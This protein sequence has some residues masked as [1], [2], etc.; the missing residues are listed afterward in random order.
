MIKTSKYHFLLSLALILTGIILSCSKEEEFITTPEA[1]LSFTTDTVLFDTVF[2]TLGSVTKKFKVHNPNDKSIRTSVRLGGGMASPYRINVDGEPISSVTE[3]TILPNDSIYIFVDVTIDPGNINQPFIQK[4]SIVFVTNGN[5]QDVKLI[6]WGQDAHYLKNTWLPDEDIVW[7]NDKPYV[8][9]DSIAIMPNR[10][11]TIE[12]GVKIYSNNNSYIWVAGT[13]I[14]NGTVDNPVIFTGIRTDEYYENIPGQWGGIRFLTPS[15]DNTITNCTVK[16][17]TIGIQVDSL[18]QNSNPKLTLENVRIENMAALGLF[19]FTGEI[20]AYNL[21]INNCCRVLLV[22]QSG[23]KYEFY[24]STFAHVNNNCTSHEPG[25]FLNNADWKNGSI[26]LVN[27][28][29]FKLVNS[30]VWGSQ[31]D[32]FVVDNTQGKGKVTLD[33]SYS[34]LRTTINDLN[35]NNN[36]LNKDPLFVLPSKYNFGLDTLSPA[37][38]KG[39][40]DYMS[41]P[42]LQKDLAGTTRSYAEPDMGALERKQ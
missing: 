18:S 42:P 41:L 6:A 2:T 9:F 27:D 10:K 17:G 39:T 32:E 26:T 14:V 21:L 15:K 4:D 3:F 37:I 33:L 36:I 7:T 23:G 40:I 13:M 25:I 1:K 35:I 8:I 20:T 19:G 29:E 31:E 28:L 22:A 38:N 34:L 12:A 5:I 16:N 11:L 24:H 30:I